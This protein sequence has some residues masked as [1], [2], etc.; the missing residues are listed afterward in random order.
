[1]G[2]TARNLATE[3]LVEH[4]GEYGQKGHGWSLVHARCQK[5]LG[6]L[7]NAG[8]T[9]AVTG[10]LGYIHE[11][12]PITHQEVTRVRPLLAKGSVGPVV[13]KAELHITVYASVKKETTIE[14][15]QIK[16]QTGTKILKNKKEKEVT[17]YHLYTRPT[18]AKAMEG[19]R[20]GVPTLPGRIE[21]P[22]VGGWDKLRTAYMKAV[23]ESRT[24]NDT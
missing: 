19:K 20:R 8:Y 5:V 18:E 15:Q 21:V 17:R 14:T 13:R 3:K 1:M 23:E 11:Q 6:D 9:W 24:L 4:I 2:F 16:T 10:H 22:M 7:E 12:D